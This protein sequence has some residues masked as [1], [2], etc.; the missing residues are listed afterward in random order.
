MRKPIG[1]P[2]SLPEELSKV[3]TAIGDA[4]REVKEKTE[5]I[6]LDAAEKRC[7]ALAGEITAWLRQEESSAVYWVEVE[8]KSRLRVRLASAP[9]D[10]APALAKA[11]VQRRFPPAS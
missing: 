1:C 10:V 6:E 11:A 9:L 2:E 3:A 8:E 7:R 5:R 4:A